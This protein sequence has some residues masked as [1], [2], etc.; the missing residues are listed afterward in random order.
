MS[1]LIFT[2][3]DS[4]TY[5]NVGHSLEVYDFT[6]QTYREEVLV[7]L[8]YSGLINTDLLERKHYE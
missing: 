2:G 8:S 6:W 1:K 3:I 4:V 5:G 7:L